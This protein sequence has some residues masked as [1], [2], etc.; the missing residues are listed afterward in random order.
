MPNVTHLQLVRPGIRKIVYDAIQSGKEP[1]FTLEQL[2]VITGTLCGVTFELTKTESGQRILKDV[3][4][5][6]DVHKSKFR[7]IL[8]ILGESE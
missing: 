2:S 1:V 5:P 4:V 6:L 7:R 3:Y 8:D